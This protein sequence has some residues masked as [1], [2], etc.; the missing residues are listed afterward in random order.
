METLN[1][2]FNYTHTPNSKP[3][4]YEVK[5]IA[6]IPE[7][8][9]EKVETVT[10]YKGYSSIQEYINTLFQEQDFKELIIPYEVL[11]LIEEDFNNICGGV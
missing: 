10:Q 7:G 5:V 1:R 4:S 6:C 2:Y 9:K 11:A 3:N 8:F